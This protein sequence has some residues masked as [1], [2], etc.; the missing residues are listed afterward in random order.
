MG[1]D[2]P[3]NTR[4][5]IKRGSC[6]RLA[7]RVDEVVTIAGHQRVEL[8]PRACHGGNLDVGTR[9]LLKADVTFQRPYH[10]HRLEGC[11]SG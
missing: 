5:V 8:D 10:L 2:D 9:E 3:W 1:R 11:R 7:D 6:P 4:I